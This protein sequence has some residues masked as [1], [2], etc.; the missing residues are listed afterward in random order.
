MEDEELIVTEELLKDLKYMLIGEF[1]LYYSKRLG[2]FS[3]QGMR[4]TE[5]FESFSDMKEWV[6]KNANDYIDIFN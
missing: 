5:A 1:E 4:T 6:N 3:I 2:M